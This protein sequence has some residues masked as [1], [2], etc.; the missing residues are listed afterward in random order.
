MARVLA[1]ANTGKTRTPVILFTTI[2]R[3]VSVPAL[4]FPLPFYDSVEIPTTRSAK[5]EWVTAAIRN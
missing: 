1:T 2:W 4:R 3:N 5:F